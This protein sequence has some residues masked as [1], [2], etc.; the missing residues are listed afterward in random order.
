AAILAA[1]LFGLWLR[2]RLNRPPAPKPVPMAPAH[3]LALA[4]LARLDGM[5]FATPEEADA[6]H[7]RLSSIFR[8]YLD[9]RFGLQAAERTTEEVVSAVTEPETAGSMATRRDLMQNFLGKCDQVKFAKYQPGGE[10]SRGLLTVATDFVHETADANARV[11]MSR[12]A[13]VS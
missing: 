8:R 7:V 10:E 12:A 2:K 6:F 5:S 1:L 13:E 9:W 11:A 4:A 3:E